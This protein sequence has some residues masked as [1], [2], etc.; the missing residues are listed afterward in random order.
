MADHR[1]TAG[2]GAIPQFNAR[3]V[4]ESSSRSREQVT[5]DAAAAA[6]GA[7]AASSRWCCSSPAP[8]SRICSWLRPPRDAA[9]SRSAPRWAR[10]A[11]R[12]VR[13]FLDREPGAGSGRRAVRRRAARAVAHRRRSRRAPATAI[14]RLGDDRGGPRRARLHAGRAL[15][16][17]GPAVR[18]GPRAPRGHARRPARG[19]RRTA[20][21]AASGGGHPASRAAAG[22]GAGG[23]R[24]WCCWWAPDCCSRAS[25]GCSGSIWASS[26][27]TGCSRRA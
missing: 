9:R 13:Q 20:G 26:P 3:L 22:G 21:A 17:R 24:R 7:R 16:G 19:A 8:T 5:G 10:A 18:A 2:G 6:A 25:P 15:G 14:P 12:M 4:G 1:G 27:S 11:R 23:A